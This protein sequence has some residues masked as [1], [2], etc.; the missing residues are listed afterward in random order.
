MSDAGPFDEKTQIIPNPGGRLTGLGRPPADASSGAP[1]QTEQQTAAML[2]DEAVGL[3]P[4]IEAAAPILALVSRLRTMFARDDLQA[5]QRRLYEDFAAFDK[6]AERAGIRPDVRATSHYALCA[7]VD[8]VA[9]STPWGG[10]N[11]W[12]GHLARRFHTD[13]SG[14]D[15]FYTFLERFEADPE[16]YG[17]DVIELFYLCLSLGFQ[18]RLGV[19]PNGATRL[20]EIRGR[21][22]RLIRR[23]R[24]EVAA[25][26][27]PHW[28][29]V[30]AP[31]RPLSSRIPLWTVAACTAVLL[32]LA[33]IGFRLALA[34]ESDALL[35]DLGVLPHVRTPALEAIPPPPP[36]PPPP[37]IHSVAQFL[38]PEIDEGLVTV[39]ETAQNVL[40]RLTGT[41]MFMPGSATLDARFSPV[42]DR[43]AAAVKDDHGLAMVVGHTDNQPIHTLQFPSNFE[44]SLARAKAVRD[45]LGKTLGSPDK[46]SVAGRGDAE[47]IG[48]NAT[49]AGRALNRRIE[50]IVLRGHAQQ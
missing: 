38:K 2:L 42:V 40:V 28:R 24:G 23:R 26:L 12:A 37:E 22:H 1:T 31:H 3:N 16:R 20:A 18:G 49:T 45:R 11:V 10:N 6:R 32:L 30:S 17:G 19:L 33:F 5:L 46:I 29:G 41:A 27:S 34:S 39:R 36:P 7:T 44:L 47:P 21:L 25:E 50:I 48:D 8:D 15:R 14:G 4:L 9:A 35:T 13:A 43:I